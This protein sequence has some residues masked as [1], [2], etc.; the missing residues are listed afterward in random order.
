MESAYRLA[1]DFRSGE[2][3][4]RSSDDWA[5]RLNKLRIHTPD[6]AVNLLANGFL[7]AQTLNG[8]IRA[9][10]G[11]YQPG[12]AFGFRDQLQDMLAMIHYEP[13]LVRRHLLHCAAR[14]FEAGDVLHWW[15]EPY[16]GVRTQIRDDLL[17]LPYV[18]ASYVQITGDEGVLWEGVPFLEDIEIPEGREDVYAA[19]KPSEHIATLHEHCMRAFR[20]AAQTGA[21][22]LCLMGAGDWNDGMNRVGVEGR[23]E[24]I[25]LSEFL[26]ACAA[27]YARI[28]PNAEDRAWLMSLNEQMIA[29][30]EENAWDGAWYLRAYTDDGMKLGGNGC[31]CCRIDL[32]SQAWAVMA[33]LDRQRCS[34]AVDAAWAQLAD[35]KQ[36]LIRLLTPPFDADVY[37]PGYIAAYPE[38]IRENGA[39]YTHAAC[40][41][42]VALAEMGDAE[43]AHRALQM[44]LPVNHAATRA[45]ADVYRVEPYVMAADVYTNPRHEGRGGWTWYTGSAAW[46]LLAILKLLGYEREENRV[47][48]NA[49]LGEWEEA[50]IELQWGLSR[51]RLVC[52]RD[53]QCVTLDGETVEG[54]SICLADDGREHIA[55]F[56]A[57]K[58]GM[59]IQKKNDIFKCIYT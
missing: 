26:A 48:M 19:M 31:E 20:R 34:S 15:H 46:M 6:D 56:P 11:L 12:G 8:R 1:R 33:G 55:V 35:E 3:L 58:E 18:A 37:D 36:K 43:R 42:L 50:Q 39:Q 4:R 2:S 22:G 54:D 17:F 13:Q 41:M 44:L 24:S 32:I 7:Q 27:E 10:T 52:R 45:D 16:T 28:A 29:A 14:Q 59:R 53:A 47:R 38:G 25:W 23:G 51:Y 21:H 9:R 5:E 57:R 49:L 30:L 40:W